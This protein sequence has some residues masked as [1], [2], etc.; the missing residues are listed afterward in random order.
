MEERRIIKIKIK[1]KTREASTF[2]SKH[3][4]STLPATRATQGRIQGV[5]REKRA[6]GQKQEEE[7]PHKVGKLKGLYCLPAAISVPAT[8]W[9]P[10]GL[11]SQPRGPGE[12]G[13]SSALSSQ[14]IKALPGADRAAEGL[15]VRGGG[16]SSIPCGEDGREGPPDHG[17]MSRGGGQGGVILRGNDTSGKEH[18]EEDDDKNN[19]TDDD[20]HLHIL[21]PELPSHLLRCR[22][23]VLRLQGVRQSVN[24]FLL[25][26]GQ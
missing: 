15:R 8:C 11:S 21:P 9:E 5:L 10:P 20:D 19:H 1:V 22:L 18:D 13:R 2:F 14:G 3:A 17:G 26:L 23:E 6:K 16:L 7:A 24:Q 12:P 25:P 4:L